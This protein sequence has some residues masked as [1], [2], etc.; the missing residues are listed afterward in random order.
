MT[1]F[2][3]LAQRDKDFQCIPKAFVQNYNYLND[4]IYNFAIFELIILFK[5]ENNRNKFIFYIFLYALVV[6]N[7]I[8]F[9]S[10]FNNHQSQETE[11]SV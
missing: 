3:Y 2:G 6:Y 9:P 1:S 7:I 11:K 5:K 10:N 4:K 8:K